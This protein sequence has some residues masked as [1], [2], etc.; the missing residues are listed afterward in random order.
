MHGDNG[1]KRFS[2]RARKARVIPAKRMADVTALLDHLSASSGQSSP[3]FQEWSEARHV[4]VNPEARTSQPEVQMMAADTPKALRLESL[5]QTS[6]EPI[7][8]DEAEARGRVA[9]LPGIPR[10]RGFEARMHIVSR[11]TKA[12]RY[13]EGMALS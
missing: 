9:R 5:P 1:E 11:Q 3:E 6:S 12:A 13:G 7:S 10:T 2:N 8:P 4:V